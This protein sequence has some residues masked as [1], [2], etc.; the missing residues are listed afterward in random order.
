MTESAHFTNLAFDPLLSVEWLAV[1]AGISLLVLIFGLWRRSRGI[2]IRFLLLALVFAL[3][4]N[5][6]LVTESRDYL[7]DTVL[8]I[9]DQSGSQKIGDRQSQTAAARLAV[10]ERLRNFENLD[11][12]FLEITNNPSGLDRQ[13]EGTA[14]FK[15][16]DD[17]LKSFPA[18]GVAATI[19]ITD[20]QVHDAPA[21][22]EASPDAGPVH[23]LL[24]GERDEIDR[25]LF[26]ETAPS[27][28][29]VGKSVTLGY[30]VVDHRPDNVASTVVVTVKLD[31]QVIRRIA[32]RTGRSETFDLEIPHGGANH[33]TLEVDPLDGELSEK[34]NLAVVTVNGVRDRLK[35]LL[36]SGEPH[37][38]ERSWRNILKS[39]PSVELVHFT[40]LRPPEKQDGTPLKE[41]SLI[42]FPIVELFEKKLE[43]FDLIVFDRYR[44]RGVLASRFL[45]NIVNYVEGGGA[46]LEAAGPSFATPLS[47]YRT[48]L[49]VVLPGVPTGSVL[50]EPYLPEVS[51]T[52]HR[53]PVTA[54]LE[55][56]YQARNWGR[57]FRLIDSEVTGG[58]VL[59][60]GPTDR[61]L[62]I[63]HRQGEGRVAQLM[64]DHAWLWGRG[65]DGG[66]PQS[67]LFRRIAHWLMKEPE[68]EE[69]NLTARPVG[70]NLQITRQ[71]LDLD[72]T[73]VEVTHPDGTKITV[74]L[75]ETGKGQFQAVTPLAGRGLYELKTTGVNNMVAVGSLNPLEERDIRATEN[76][77]RPATTATDGGIHWISD[78][79]MPDLRR[80]D[81]ASSQSSD[82]WWG[83]RANNRFDVT[84][85]SRTTLLPPYLGVLLL[86][87][88]L[89]ALWWREGR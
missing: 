66:G 14:L 40:I 84:G 59:M 31:G 19:L 71:T 4:A 12:E 36:V 22:E 62:L 76:R 26:V 47:L 3:L 41:L 44:R 38:G 9:T 73:E 23:V 15:A 11:V 18:N 29:I 67:E 54:S 43:E 34:N 52:G 21:A 49:S 55:D 39:D 75:E 58:D 24:S 88:I 16:R 78:G 74:N 89:A 6:Y 35:V 87:S 82:Y 57:W 5:P 42:P 72:D 70:E 61:P 32:S 69:E 50:E 33:I 83:L 37:M 51:K 56:R 30:K 53:H 1:L 80:T 63:L 77:L 65:F 85:Y 64:S 60:T 17:Y 46:L 2:S 8:V 86:L 81:P 48:P 68:L 25:I 13:S 45:N 20:G 27:F 10:E 7:N 79:A 28:G